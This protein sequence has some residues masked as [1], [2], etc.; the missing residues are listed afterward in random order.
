MR[1][2]VERGALAVRGNHDDA[3]IPGVA[4]TMHQAA[5]RGDRLDPRP[6]VGRAARLPREPPLTIAG[7]SDLPRP[8][9]P[10]AAA[11]V[12]LRDR[13]VRAADGARRRGAGDVGVLRARARARAVHYRCG[14]AARPVPPRPRGRRSPCRRTAA[15][16]RWSGRRAA[17][18]REHR[19]LLR[20][21]RH[22]PP[23]L[24]FHRVP[25]DWRAAAPR[26][27]RRGCR[28][29]LARRLERGERWAALLDPGTEIDGYRIERQVH[30]GGMAVIYEVTA[31][32]DPGFPLV[33]KVPRLGSASRPRASSPSR[34]SSSSTPP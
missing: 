16:S 30:A 5:E 23:A 26:S 15:G 33:M 6:P 7:G 22:R 32:E 14:G 28:S 20:H 21:A 1:G 25:Y 31:R 11:R 17:A 3:A 24:T 2:H 18:R 8:R 10:R 13:P 9:E 12:D 34:S 29:A 27:A 19:R 4:G